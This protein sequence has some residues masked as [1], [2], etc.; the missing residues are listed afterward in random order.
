[1]KYCHDRKLAHLDI[2]PHNILVDVIKKE[3]L[4]IDFGSAEFLNHEKEKS[5]NVIKDFIKIRYFLKFS[6]S[7]YLL[8]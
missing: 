5:L 4:L 3:I 6:I 2:K 8:I 7:L 1:M